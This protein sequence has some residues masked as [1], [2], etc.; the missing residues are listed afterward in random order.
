[1]KRISIFTLI[2]TL[3]VTACQEGVIEQN[4]VLFDSEMR[5]NISTPGV[6]TKVAN[7]AFEINDKI[8]LYVTDYASDNVPMPLQL[9]GN[10]ANNMSL[11]YDGANWTPQESIYWGSGK[12][13]IYAYYPYSSEIS[14][15]NDQ[16]FELALDQTGKGFESSDFLW[17]KATGLKQ[18]DGAVNLA[19]KHIMSKISIK[20]VAGDDYIGSLPEDASVLLHSTV[21][22]GRIDLEKGAI[23]KDPYSGAKSIQMRNL[24]VQT[25][26]DVKMVVYEAIVIPQMLENTVPLFE[27]NSKSVSY[28]IED[29][30]NFRPGVAY[31]YTATLNTSTNAIKVEIGCETE[32]WNNAGSGGSGDSGNGDNGSGDGNGDINLSEYTDLSAP[33]TANCYLINEAGKYKFKAVQG[34]TDGIAGNIKSVE[35]LWESFG[36]EVMPNVGDII[37]NVRYNNGYISFNTPEEFKEGNAVIAAKNSKGM[38]LWSWHMW[39]AKEKWNELT[40]PNNAG[41]VMDRNLGALSATPGDVGALGLLYQWGRKDPFPGSASIS[42]NIIS[43]T[44]GTWTTGE[45][46]DINSTEMNPMCMSTNLSNFPDDAWSSTKTAYDPCPHGWQVPYGDDSSLWQNAGFTFV[47]FD[48][49]NRGIFFDLGDGI[50]TWYPASGRGWSMNIDTVGTYGPYWTSTSD[51]GARFRFSL[52]QS[53]ISVGGYS[54]KCTE[55]YAVRCQKETNT[56]SSSNTSGNEGVD[57]NEGNGVWE[58][59]E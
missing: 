21:T 11:K 34:N 31:T 1:M 41:I 45:L 10:R 6:Q 55:A 25:Q 39:C 5:F 29:F 30:F 36:T 12:S 35:V 48:K 23:S 20:L 18:T 43:A 4:T 26:N 3:A 46:K 51:S 22:A 44:T 2:L 14:D 32:D 37:T 47:A 50:T 16:Y 9:S 54:N 13:D 40:Y 52:S 7:G 49:E 33:G 56:N 57:T 28:I 58:T 27:I 19:M 53:S 59:I 15:V 8:G 17:A 24:G 42:E 38:V